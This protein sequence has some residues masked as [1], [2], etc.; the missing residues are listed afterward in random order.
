MRN[1]WAQYRQKKVDERASP[2]QPDAPPGV[3][4]F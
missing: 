1:A 2:E 3:P 4:R